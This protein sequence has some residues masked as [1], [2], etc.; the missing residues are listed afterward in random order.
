[1]PTSALASAGASLIPAPALF[2]QLLY[3]GQFVGRPH[4][5]IDFVNAADRLGRGVPLSNR[6][7]KARAAV[8]QGANTLG[9]ARFDG[10]Q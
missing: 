1:M 4:F 7:Y 2:L 3:Q 10:G 5:H 9:S 6:H 8:M